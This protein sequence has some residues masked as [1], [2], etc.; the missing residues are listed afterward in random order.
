MLRAFILGRQ[1]KLLR[2]TFDIHILLRE[3]NRDVV[4]MEEISYGDK[5]VTLD[6]HQTLFRIRDP[7]P[8]LQVHTAVSESDE[9]RFRFR[10]RQYPW[11]SFGG[12]LH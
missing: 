2:E 5:D 10:I 12:L 8:Q 1:G 7:Y 4:L 9:T 6:V 11:N 3:G